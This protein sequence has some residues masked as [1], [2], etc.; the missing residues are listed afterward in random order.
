MSVTLFD[1]QHKPP[2]LETAFEL[3]HRHLAH[4]DRVTYRFLGHDVPNRTFMAPLTGSV[5][6][7]P[8]LPERRAAQLTRGP[9]FTFVPRT[10]LQLPRLP[11]GLPESLDELMSL[12]YGAFDIGMAVASSLITLTGDS[13]LDPTRHRN[14]VRSTLQGALAAFDHVTELVRDN[15]PDLVYVFNGRFAYE[16]AVMR[17]CQAQSVPV[18]IHERGSTQER[19]FLAPFTPHD[20]K[21][22]QAEMRRRWEAVRHDAV[23]VEQAV[24]W[25]RARRDGV[26]RDWPSFTSGQAR[27]YLPSLEPGK[28]LIAYFSSSDDEYVAIGDDFR[29]EG[30]QG[31]LDAVRALVRVVREVPDAQLVIRVHPHLTTKHVTERGRWMALASDDASVSVIA[32]ESEV[33]TYALIDAAEVVVTSG[34]TVG[35]EAVY[36]GRPSVLLGPSDYDLLDAV[37]LARDEAALRTLLADGSLGADPAAALAYGCYRATYGE[38]FQVYEPSEFSHG[39]FAGVRLRPTLWRTLA[40]FRNRALERYRWLGPRGR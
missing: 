23:E 12:R 27:S 24:A 16:R 4:Q 30:W 14:A 39:R 5:L 11:F 22:V 1:F 17:A 3:V 36:W 20:R 35:M 19:F 15:R 29:W 21:R 18:L 32:P 25:F 28:R 8:A 37:H 31:Q 33:D 7:G 38:P 2:H 9:G 6:F 34:S 13:R 10:R 40:T 26:P